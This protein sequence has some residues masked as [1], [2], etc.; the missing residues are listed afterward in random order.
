MSEEKK[1]DKTATT[2]KSNSITETILC[3]L[4]WLRVSMCLCIV[5]SVGT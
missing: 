1:K 3:A 4:L 2:K 5:A